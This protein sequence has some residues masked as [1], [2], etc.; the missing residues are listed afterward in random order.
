MA[1]PSLADLLSGLEAAQQKRSTV[2][3][4]DRNVIELVTKLK[5]L[6]LLGEELLHTTNGREYLTRERL[7][8]EVADAVDAAGG[9]LPLV[10]ACARVVAPPRGSQAPHPLS[11]DDTAGA[12]AV[13][14]LA[15]AG[16]CWLLLPAFK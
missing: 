13:L 3:L 14:L 1:G 4:S 8:A 15:A 5:A 11:L 9:R 7:R 6:G 12:G 16:C 10:R 2:K